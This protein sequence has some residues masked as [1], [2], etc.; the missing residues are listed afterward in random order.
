MSTEIGS[1]AGA[2]GWVVGN[3]D[4]SELTVYNAAGAAVATI[5]RPLGGSLVGASLTLG[6]AG[7]SAY[8][9]PPPAQA[10]GGQDSTFGAVGTQPYLGDVPIA[11][12]ASWVP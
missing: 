3:S 4:W 2:A 5:A 8:L 12:S 1:P 10:A 11:D 6:F 9:D 7:D